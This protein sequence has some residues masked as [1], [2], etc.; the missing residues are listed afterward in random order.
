MSLDKAIIHGREHRKPY[1]K[2]KSVDTSCRNHGDC[3]S[4]KK[5]RLHKVISDNELC[6]ILLK[7]YK[8]NVDER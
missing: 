8:E 1:K 6:N 7:Y 3:W 5:N 2:P 4:C